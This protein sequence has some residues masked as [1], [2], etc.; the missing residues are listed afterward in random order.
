MVMRILMGNGSR[1]K[2]SEKE[3]K[4]VTDSSNVKMNNTINPVLTYSNLIH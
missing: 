1:K 2:Q 3:C 4:Q